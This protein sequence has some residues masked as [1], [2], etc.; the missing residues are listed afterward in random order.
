LVTNSQHFKGDPWYLIRETKPDGTPYDDGDP[1]ADITRC[2]V[3]RMIC[4]PRY[5]GL[6]RS[7]FKLIITKR[8]KF[9]SLVEKLAKLEIVLRVTQRHAELLPPATLKEIPLDWY[10]LY[11][12]MNPSPPTNDGQDVDDEM[13]QDD[14]ENEMQD[15]DDADAQG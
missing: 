10:M 9:H 3:I 1:D 6:P 8:S 11:K 2:D 5:E 12:A 15:D 4:A 14:D 13:Q 7:L